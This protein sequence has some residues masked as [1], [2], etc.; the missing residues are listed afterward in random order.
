VD[1]VYLFCRSLHI[2][3]AVI[4]LGGMLFQAV[5][6]V[7]VFKDE[8]ENSK[9][10]LRKINRRFSAFAWLCILTMASTGIVLMLRNPNFAPFRYRD[11]WSI[12]LGFK[13]LIFI[14]MVL[15][16]Y[17]YTQMLKYLDSPSSNGGFNER[18]EIF[19]HRVD[20]FQLISILLGTLA[21]ILAASM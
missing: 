6:L 14:L 19:R 1:I 3:A 18:A 21:V 11:A 13:Q 20:Q 8:R 15:Y 9:A 16:A 17:G 4:W 5:I 10:T 2:L 12:I 7:P